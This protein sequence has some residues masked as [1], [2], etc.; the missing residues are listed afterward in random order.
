[1][2]A[3]RRALRLARAG[4]ALGI[5]LLASWAPTVAGAAARSP[6]YAKRGMVVSSQA[7]AT[8]AGVE[9]L[10]AGGNAVD[11][12]VATAFA[13]GVAQPYSTGIGGGGFLLIHRASGEIVAVDAR[14]TAPAAA[15]R[16]MYVRPGV[17]EQASLAGPL[18]VA[19][20]GMVAG[21]A[22]VLERYGT[23]PLA[24]VMAPAIRLAEAGFTIGPVHAGVL[25]RMRQ[26]G[27]PERFPETGRIQF[28]PAG[29]PAAPGMRL[30]QTDLAATLRA[31]AREGPD[32]FYRGSIADAIATALEKEGGLVTRADLAAYQPK[33]REPV[34][35]TYRSYEVW[36]FPPPSSGGAVLIEM[37]N[38]LEGFDLARRGAGSSAS[39]HPIA[40]AMKLA[41]ADR[42]AWFGDPDFVEVPV[43]RLTD[44]AYAA[45]LR[46]RLNPPWWRRSPW[47]WGQGETAI[48]VRGAGLPLDDSGTAHFS[49][50]DAAGNAVAMTGTINTPFGSGITVPGTGIVLNTEMD[51][52]AM[53]PHAP[54]VYGLVD[55]RGANAIAPG[56]RP[57]SSMTPTILMRDGRPVL[58][59]G[60]PG[61]PRIITT[62]LLSILNVVDYGMDVQ[63]AVS[64]PRF[65]HQWV[66]D[67][68]YVEPAIPEDV[69]AGLRQRGHRVEVATDDWS[70]AQ[71]IAIDPETGWLTGGTDPR[72]DGLAR[73]Y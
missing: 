70:S 67:T 43:V 27:M 62:V 58:V 25:E 56:K 9:I 40:E 63:A 4:L 23:M 64:A 51:D 47:T 6:A 39:L 18:A 31:I 60:S 44:K 73:G 36:S 65:H 29:T 16:D 35:G 33:L 48:S 55:T 7:D 22:L 28:P 49:V 41:F 69:V 53:A 32:A 2:T 17:P 30:V 21:L 5:G 13:L 66:P 37:L 19:T 38:I 14:E 26:F 24:E 46:A 34:R 42:A 54:N 3:P 8:R 45:A 11:A 71:A 10:E 61:G 1:V 68:L 52:F 50:T 15:D 12:A 72:S 59:T 20:P 57:L